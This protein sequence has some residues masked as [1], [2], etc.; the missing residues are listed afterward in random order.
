VEI[1]RARDHYE[2]QQRRV[3]LEELDHS[4]FLFDRPLRAHRTYAAVKRGLDIVAGLLGVTV[5]AVIVPILWVLMR[6]DDKGPL[7]YRQE[8]IGRGGKPFRILKFRSMRV[9]AESGGPRWAAQS[10]DRITRVGRVLRRT[11]IDEFPQFWNVLRGE[12]TLV[13]PRPERAQ[14]IATL[15]QAIPFYERRH[16]MRPGITGW[17]TV[18]FGY[19]DSVSDKWHSHE[20]DLYYLKHRSARL[21][22]EILL[23]T[24]VVMLMR[25]GQ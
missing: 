18:R 24:C 2:R 21:D 25:R 6:F 20:Y 1:R 14:F 3:L 17:A 19:G 22:A 16:Y 4:W 23:R 11:R 12:M 8:R 10:D 5:V 9:D 15:I 7:F 13:G